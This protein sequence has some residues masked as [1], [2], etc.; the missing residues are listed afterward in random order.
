MEQSQKLFLALLAEIFGAA[1]TSAADL[2]TADSLL[3]GFLVRLADSHDFAH[4]L[5]LRAQF[6]LCALEFFKR[7]AGKFDHDVIAG[8]HVFIQRAVFAARDVRQI[9][10]AGQHSGDQR[11]RKACRLA[12]QSRG[13]RGAGID[14]N[15]QD[16]VAHRIVGKLYIGAADDLD[17]VHDLVGGLL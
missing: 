16:A 3:E 12:G 13:A 4:S 6:I 5:H 14:L 10:S 9:Q 11:D 8:G 2:Q 7:P 17:L 1:Q 15:D